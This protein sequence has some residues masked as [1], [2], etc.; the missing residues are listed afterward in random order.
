M[1]IIYKTGDL[2]DCTEPWILHGCNCQGVMGSG[3]A[4]AIRDKYPS[5]YDVYK[6]WEDQN[7]L[8]LGG[9]IFAEQDDGK[10]IFNGLT[11]NFYGRDGKCYV[12]Y[13]AVREVIE[14]I[15]DYA[16]KHYAAKDVGY[17]PI[18]AMPKIGAGLGGGD[19]KFISTII[20]EC[21]HNFQPVVY[22]I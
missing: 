9:V 7:G 1:K 10:T 15:D 21:S 13:N 16:A 6:V 20:E 22:T 3:V 4:K 8:E 18:V 12:D 2:L 11:Q 17:M 14:A 19:W 5:A